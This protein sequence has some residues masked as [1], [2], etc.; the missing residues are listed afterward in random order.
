MYMGEV[1]Q[2][3]KTIELISKET[4]IVD[5]IKIKLS[6]PSDYL[7]GRATSKTNNN[8]FTNQKRMSWLQRGWKELITEVHGPNRKKRRGILD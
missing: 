8:R 5:F 2:P 4:N 6:H 7:V 3:G 1:N